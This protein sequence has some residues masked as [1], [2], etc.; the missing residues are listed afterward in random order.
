MEV[1]PSYISTLESG[2]QEPSKLLLKV[3]KYEMNVNPEWIASGKGEPYLDQE[4]N[5]SYRD[6]MT[7]NKIGRNVLL[8]AAVLG[9]ILPAGAAGLAIGVGASHMLDK[10]KK[11]YDVKRTSELAEK[12]DVDNSAISRWKKDNKIPAKYL[13]KT[14]QETH[15]ELPYFLV[16]E[17]YIDLGVREIIAFT[18]RQIESCTKTPVDIKVLE[19]AFQKR[20]NYDFS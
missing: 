3:M 6:T 14:A 7:K 1:S 9:P 13:Q 16:N 17:D 12:L 20:F 11:A 10:M 4:M 15:K 2:R 19:Q 8:F 18:K 5:K